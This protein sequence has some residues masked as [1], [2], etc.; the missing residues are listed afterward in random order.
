MLVIL[1]M[2]PLWTLLPWAPCSITSHSSRLSLPCLSVWI[3]F[4]HLING[5]LFF[6]IRDIVFVEYINVCSCLASLLEWSETLG[7]VQRQIGFHVYNQNS[8]T[9]SKNG[10]HQITRYRPFSTKIP[11]WMVMLLRYLCLSDTVKYNFSGPW[12]NRRVGAL[13]PFHKQF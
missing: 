4:I 2:Y 1:R 11:W 9:F 13:D 8:N 3:L 5:I 6:H 7:S 10:R 12:N